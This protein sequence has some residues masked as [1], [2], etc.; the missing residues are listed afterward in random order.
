M[1]DRPLVSVII[2]FLDT[3][4][5][6][7]EAID[8]VLAQTYDCWELLLV[9]DGSGDEST[10]IAHDYA[11][12]YPEQIHYFEHLAHRN[13]GMSASR[14][15]GIH[16]AQGEYI[17]FLDADDVWLPGKLEYQVG[18]LDTQP[19]AGMVYGNTLYWYSWTR[20]PGD[21]QR[22]HVPQLG[23]EPNTLVEPPHLLQLYLSGRAAVPCTCSILVRRKAIK[24]IDGFEESFP[25]MYE[26]Q[27]FYAKICL[28]E[29]IY[30]SGEC[31]DRYRQHSDSNC[32]VA[33]NSGQDQL[34]RL[35][36]LEWLAG[37]LSQRDIENP[38]IWLTLSRELWLSQQ[39]GQPYLSKRTTYLIR[40][41]KKWVL[42]IEELIVPAF[43]RRW[44][45]IRGEGRMI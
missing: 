3:E 11:R 6:I 32:S 1:Y 26:D 2:I 5:F 10:K 27:V 23:V 37:Y 42:R 36:F 29:R 35:T 8:S 12:K 30:V 39:P 41:F 22:D 45:W 40:W 28:T 4:K 14:N 17:A 15:L 19:E 25:G 44:L 16:H 24:Q 7:E 9:D 21:K 13:L 34:A 20:Q 38:D 18:I 33:V 43:V 31:L